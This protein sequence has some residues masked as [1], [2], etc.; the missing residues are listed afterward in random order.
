MSIS[1][2]TD[3]SQ[4]PD[5]LRGYSIGKD[6]Y[7]VVSFDQGQT[8]FEIDTAKDVTVSF[9]TTTVDTSC[10]RSGMYRENLPIV[11]ELS[12]DA[13]ML[14]D[15]KDNVCKAIEHASQSN[16]IFLLGAF[17]DSGNGPLFYACATD[18]SRPE[19]LEGVVRLSA[20][21]SLTRFINWFK[22]SSVATAAERLTEFGNQS[23]TINGKTYAHPFTKV[24]ENHANCPIG[25][26]AGAGGTSASSSSSSSH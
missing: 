10:R 24:D 12:G 6:G 16:G 15:L 3:K 19:E 23:V 20:K 22:G 8:F 5:D 25:Y 17:T 14:F 1:V 9:S 4:W 26:V 2:Q 21:Y 13:E 7:L 11:N 18:M